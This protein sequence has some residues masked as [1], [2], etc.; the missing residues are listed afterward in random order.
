MP[1]PPP[2]NLPL[3][4]ISIPFFNFSDPPSSR[5]G[6]QNL[7]LPPLKEKGGGGVPNYDN[8]IIKIIIYT[9]QFSL[10]TFLMMAS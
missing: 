4:H 9:D 5:G 1:V 3:H 7:L 2:F 10:L 8:S 6:N